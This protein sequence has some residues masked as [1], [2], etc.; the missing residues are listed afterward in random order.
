MAGRSSLDWDASVERGGKSV[1]C[2]EIGI[3]L[4]GRGSEFDLLRRQ[5]N[6]RA[7]RYATG[8]AGGQPG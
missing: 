1:E 5:R 2:I 7:G 4:D 8:R 3:H 6:R